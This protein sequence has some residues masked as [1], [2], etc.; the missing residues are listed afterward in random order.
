M[1]ERILVPLDGS[2]RAERALPVAAQLAHV[3]GG[4]VI[5]LRV[6]AGTALAIWAM[7]ETP[8]LIKE[9]IESAKARAADY[10]ARVA[11][12]PELAG[13]TVQTQVQSGVPAQCIL[14]AAQEHLADLIILGSH[15]ET[16]FKRWLLGSV[17]QQV[18]R[19][20]PVPVLVLHER[21]SVPTHLSSED[22]Q[23]IRILVALDGSS[24]AE[25]A[26][27]PAAYLSAALSAPARGALHLAL[28]VPLPELAISS[29]RGD[30][31]AMRDEAKRQ[32]MAYLEA[33]M[34]RLDQ[35]ELASLD[36]QITASVAIQ[37]DVAETL[38]SMAET[39]AH[40]EGSEPAGGSYVLALATHGRSGVN[41]WMMGSVAERI[42]GA[43]ILP[44]LIIRPQKMSE[45]E[46]G[47]DKP[48]A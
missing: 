5:L 27:M 45:G 33:V 35:G 43:T 32:A 1:F 2:E 7:R 48:G 37:P 47:L 21:G 8:E 42:L 4:S 34:H 19:H 18:T 10:L 26:L 46:E 23:P 44:L 29:Q 36:L 38:I 40:L 11:A 28:V 3:S 24:L 39:G 31:P 12:S 22:Q 13:L 17:A 14:S 20:S 9:T 30:L 25:V 6:A 41:R 15:G 16:G